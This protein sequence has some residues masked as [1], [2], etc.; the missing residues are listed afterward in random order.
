M[1]NQRQRTLTGSQGRS[2]RARSG[3]ISGYVFRII[4]EQLGHGQETIAEEFRVSVDTIAGWESGRRSL[5]AVPVGQMLVHRHRLMKLGASPALLLALERA[6]EADVLL[7]GALDDGVPDDAN[8]LGAWVMQ[9]DLV[10][11]LTWPLSGVAPTPLRDLPAPRHARRGPV[12]AGPELATGDRPRFFSRMRRT[13]ERARDPGLFLLRRQALYLAGYDDAPDTTDW[14]AAHQAD[15]RPSDW[16]SG[17]LNARSVAAVAARQGDRDRMGHF[18]D[19]TLDGD[20]AGEAA[21]LAYWAYWIGETPHL[22]LSDDFITSTPIGACAGPK[23]LDH[24]V[25]GLTPEHGFFDLNVHSLWALLAVRPALLRSS[26]EASRT[27]RQQLPVVLDG[28]ELSG[29]AR[30]ELEGIR[31]AIRLAEA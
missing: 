26:T 20:D 30:R 2:P 3:V 31:Y 29:R 9:R 18:I 12:P 11:V 27:L 6:L 15:V 10:E 8:P 16:L 17:W 24:L 4:R 21:N 14:L 1:A 13:V 19:Q 23:L 28:R 22:Q 7:A 5:T 25:R